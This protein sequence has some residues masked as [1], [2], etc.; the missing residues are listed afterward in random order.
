MG[1]RGP[2]DEPPLASTRGYAPPQTY[3][4]GTIAAII[5]VD[6]ETGE[7]E[8]RR[9]VSVH[10]CG[11]MINPAIVEGQIV[12]AIAQGIG[13]VLYEDLVYDEDGQLLSGDAD[14]LP[15]PLHD[16]GAVDRGRA[17][18]RRPRT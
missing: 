7:V 17:T 3:S 13:A 15:L 2:H 6:A 10:D 4:N 1:V 9:L 18:S 12:G 14:G 16:R 5:E 11:V 8:F